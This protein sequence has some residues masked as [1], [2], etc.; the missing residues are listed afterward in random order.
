MRTLEVKRPVLRWHG[1]KW[2]LAPWIISYLPPHRVY[3][4]PFGGAGSVLLRKPRSYA[5]VYNDLDNE[6]VN[7]FRILR[8]QDT[9][10]ELRH[11]L[12]L[13]PFARQEFLES[14]EPTTDPIELARRLVIRCFM[15]F[16]SN[17]HNPKNRSGFRAN[18]NRSGTT[19]AHDWANWPMNMG[20]LVNRLQGV[21]ID[22]RDAAEVIAQHDSSETLFYVDPPYP[23]GT[24]VGLKSGK[25]CYRYEMTDEAHEK[26]A[27]VLHR[28]EGMVVLS[29]YPCEMYD[30]KLYSD[31]E[32][33][34]RQAYANGARKRIEVLWLNNRAATA[35]EKSPTLFG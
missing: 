11:R 26:L 6:V 8:D 23:F 4:E 22:N 3:V 29:G 30:S 25:K 28:V 9:A 1:G 34:E 18:S 27:A 12:L 32:R 21:V 2:K 19:P 20:A 33:F 16:G 7:L 13:T 17:A 15:G 10:E 14:Y 24:R 5:E 31:W 35:L